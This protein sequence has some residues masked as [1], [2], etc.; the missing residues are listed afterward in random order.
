MQMAKRQTKERKILMNTLPQQSSSDYKGPTL[1][2]E[3]VVNAVK[4]QSGEPDFN[5]KKK[6]EDEEVKKADEEEKI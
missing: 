5:E 4:G 6:N 1:G 2:S 3:E